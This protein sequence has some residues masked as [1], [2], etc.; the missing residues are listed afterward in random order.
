MT[1]NRQN[2]SLQAPCSKTKTFNLGVKQKEDLPVNPLYIVG[3]SCLALKLYR[4]R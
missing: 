1:A 2:P 3:I 4:R